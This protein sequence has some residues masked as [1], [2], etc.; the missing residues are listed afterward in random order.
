MAS[1]MGTS[2]FIFSLEFCVIRLF[3]SYGKAQ[4]YPTAIH[5]D[6]DCSN[7]LE[8]MAEGRNGE[9]TSKS[10]YLPITLIITGCSKIM[11]ILLQD[12]CQIIYGLCATNLHIKRGTRLKYEF[13]VAEGISVFSYQEEMICFKWNDSLSEC[14]CVRTASNNKASRLPSCSISMLITKQNIDQQTCGVII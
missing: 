2:K 11:G 13:F 6:C 8:Q 1:S 5:V 10:K 3:T 9:I 4:G 14:L 7:I 12:R